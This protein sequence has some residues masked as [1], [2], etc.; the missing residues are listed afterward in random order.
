MNID[1]IFENLTPFEKKQISECLEALDDIEKEWKPLP[2]PQTQAYHSEADILFYGGS[3]G[4][5]KSDLLLG[6]S[7]K[8]HQKSIIFRRE[9]T[10]LQ[11]LIE[12]GREIFEKTGIASFNQ[13]KNIWRFKD[14]RIIQLGAC[15]HLGSE[16]KFQG[17]AHDFK[18]FDEITHY[19]ES[20]FRFLCGW[21]R[22]T[23]K[24]Q[25]KRIVCAGNPPTTAE[26]DWVIKYWSPW[27]DEH[28]PNPA[29][30]GELRYFTTIKGEDIECQ[31]GEPFYEKNELISPKSRTFIPGTVNDNPYLLESGYKSTLQSL[32]EPLRSKML[33]GDFGAGREDDDW[34]VIPTE[35][36]RI[37]QERGK[38]RKRPDSQITSI[39]VDVARGGSDKT[40]ITLRYLNYVEKQICYPGKNTP[41]GD[42]VSHLVLKEMKN[43][44]HV[45]VDVIGV[46]SSVYDALRRHFQNDPRQKSMIFGFNSAHSSSRTDR[47]K[48][49]SFYNKRAEAYWTL[50]EM[51][52]PASGDDVCLPDDREL[53]ADL[54]AAR[55]D[56]RSRGILIEDKDDIIKRIGRSPDKADSLAYAFAFPEISAHADRNLNTFGR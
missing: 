14:G 17:L 5:G 29:R 9:Y 48:M 49:L 36:V 11:G 37:A 18:G 4:A 38:E 50:R 21:L 2:G 43:N 41:D 3:A 55:W 24:S 31:S 56:F 6:L 40:V 22:S 26:G 30:P 28:H 44:C 34:Q 1:Y 47:T 42:A 45:F 53:L 46:G 39:G 54:C 10:Q 12:R 51:L 33:Y 32:P 35:W 7:S 25:R 20:Q 19:H 23:D 27:I 15:A 16:S 52:D 8:E 13:V